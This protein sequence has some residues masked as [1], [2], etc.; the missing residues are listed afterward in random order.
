MP[1]VLRLSR[2]MLIVVVLSDI[3]LSRVMSSVVILNDI[4]LGVVLLSFIMLGRDILSV[5]DAECSN[6]YAAIMSAVTLS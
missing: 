4:M 1:N 6:I 2:V 3:M 5:I